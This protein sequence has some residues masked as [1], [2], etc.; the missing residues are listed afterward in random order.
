MGASQKNYAKR[1]KDI[2]SMC[3]M[4]PFIWNSRKG[5]SIEIESWIIIGRDEGTW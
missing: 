5:G 1:K 2:K 3:Q 4:M